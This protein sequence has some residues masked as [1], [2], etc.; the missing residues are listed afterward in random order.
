MSLIFYPLGTTSTSK[1]NDVREATWK[2]TDVDPPTTGTYY[3]NDPDMDSPTI[4]KIHYQ[5]VNGKFQKALL[6][7]LNNAG[8]STYFLE[9]STEAGQRV[10][11]TVNSISDNSTYAEFDVTYSKGA[12]ALNNIRFHVDDSTEIYFHTE[13]SGT[14]AASDAR[15]I[16]RSFMGELTGTMPSDVSAGTFYYEDS[17]NHFFVMTDTSA[18][19]SDQ[20][21]IRS[22][23]P[24]S[25]I[26]IWNTAKTKKNI[27]A[28]KS[29]TYYVSPGTNETMV[30]YNWD[31]TKKVADEFTL[32]GLSGNHDFQF[33]YNTT[34]I[35]THVKADI[36][37]LTSSKAYDLFEYKYGGTFTAGGIP[38]G[39]VSDNYFYVSSNA[40]ELCV[41]IIGAAEYTAS[42]YDFFYG[43]TPNSYIK[44]FSTTD[45]KEV[46]LKIGPA[47]IAGGPGYFIW[48]IEVVWS[49]DLLYFT[50]SWN[51]HFVNNSKYMIEF[52][53]LPSHTHV[54]ADITDFAHTH[55]KADITDYVQG[56]TS[57]TTNTTLTGAGTSGDPLSVA[58]AVF[59]YYYPRFT[60]GGS[61]THL[62]AT[63][64]TNGTFFQDA[65][66]N[67]LCLTFIDVDSVD[68]QWDIRM[69]D[70]SS[71]IHIYNSD[72]TKK[73]RYVI[74]Q[75][76]V[77][78]SN[79]PPYI[80]IKY[81]STNLNEE[82]ALTGLC[83]FSFLLNAIQDIVDMR[84]VLVITPQENEILTYSSG[85]WTNKGKE[86][87]I[88]TTSSTTSLN[89]AIVNS[90]INYATA[91]LTNVTGLTGHL[92]FKNNT[93]RTLKTIITCSGTATKDGTAGHVYIN[94]TLNGG[95]DQGM[96]GF[97]CPGGTIGSWSNSLYLEL[98]AGSYFYMKSSSSGGNG[99]INALTSLTVREV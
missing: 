51:N 62:S 15:F 30:V 37:D 38:S 91:G 49:E 98:T 61:Y 87:A 76:A 33:E 5:D 85:L 80:E 58:T 66:N 26:I 63:V 16:T 8:V 77:N 20:D 50:F 42:F 53:V 90:T 45:A 36:T 99:T 64:T 83:S 79:T 28:I 40:Q 4:I 39:G 13:S 54:K 75:G 65:V 12:L 82:F 67:Y 32:S 19:G 94:Y 27:Y 78:I 73:N 9:L 10:L 22:F 3:A 34:A 89:A 14:A 6:Y 84:D 41:S 74:T 46:T 21:Y 24:P 81:D 52:N 95:A 25:N 68:H 96:G 23:G 59:P 92:G 31:P 97:Y 17:T 29:K 86:L 93:S 7:S 70:Y 71:V 57:V 1:D 60:Y 88:R 43:I 11:Y 47:V 69:L 44:I 72:K 18:V 35:H 48:P 55:V 2:F 56:I